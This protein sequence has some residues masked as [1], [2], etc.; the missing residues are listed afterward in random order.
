[1]TIKIRC[2]LHGLTLEDAKEEILC[3]LNTCWKAKNYYITCIHGHNRG[4]VLRD[5]LRSK[6]FLEEMQS[7]GF[8]LFRVEKDYSGITIII[9]KNTSWTDMNNK[10]ELKI[11]IANKKSELKV[12]AQNKIKAGKKMNLF[13]AQALYEEI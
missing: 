9:F 2:D 8:R 4:H 6:R 5:Y 3:F 12:K 10:D 7:E 11:N 13:E 1:M